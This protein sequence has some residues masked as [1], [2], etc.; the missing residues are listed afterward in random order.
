ML[1]LI[2]KKCRVPVAASIINGTATPEQLADWRMEAELVVAVE[3]AVNSMI[4]VCDFSAGDITTHIQLDKE[5]FDSML[6]LELTSFTGRK[7][8][9]DWSADVDRR[10]NEYRMQRLGDGGG[11][12]WVTVSEVV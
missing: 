11:R 6:H 2:T 12:V 5:F 4:E 7:D 9:K 3:D 10:G 1:P 8:G